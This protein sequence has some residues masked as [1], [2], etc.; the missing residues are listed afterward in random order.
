MIGVIIFILLFLTIQIINIIG[1]VNITNF[2]FNNSS[3]GDSKSINLTNTQMTFI[4]I[5]VI[6]QILTVLGVFSSY[7]DG[8][9]N[10]Q[11]SKEVKTFTV[12]IYILYA[13][14]LFFITK[15]GFGSTNN[16]D[17]RIVNLSDTD[18]I[19][20]KITAIMQWASIVFISILFITSIFLYITF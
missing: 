14:G 2:A 10:K 17:K 18:M 5:S 6:L 3:D 19:F 16:G 8:F 20:V 12:L 15:F 13:V 4:R 11:K 1:Y 7:L 9:R